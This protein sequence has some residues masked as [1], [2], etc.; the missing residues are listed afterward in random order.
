M[1]SFLILAIDSSL[2][3]SGLA[4]GTE[5]PLA[6]ELSFLLEQPE[7]DITNIIKIKA[8]FIKKLSLN[9]FGF[10]KKTRN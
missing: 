4:L 1:F 6:K 2:F 5:S 7:S 3:I 9:F 10:I 8:H